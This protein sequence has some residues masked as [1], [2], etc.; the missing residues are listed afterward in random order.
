MDPILLDYLEGPVILA[1]LVGLTYVVKV[2]FWGRGPIRRVKGSVQQQ[3][4]E[5]RLADVEDRWEQLEAHHAGQLAD[6]EGRL[7][8]AERLLAQQQTPRLHAPEEPE[9]PTPV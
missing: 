5:E 2:M 4:L 7:D 9:V 6:L 1:T 8:F 3:A